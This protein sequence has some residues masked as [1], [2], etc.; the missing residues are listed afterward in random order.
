[1][2]TTAMLWVVVPLLYLPFAVVQ[3][4]NQMPGHCQ[5]EVGRCVD[6]NGDRMPEGQVT[7]LD[8]VD[9]FD[10]DRHQACF[11]MCNARGGIG[12]EL[13]WGAATGEAGC[14]VY[15]GDLLAGDVDVARGDGSANRTCWPFNQCQRLTCPNG[16]APTALPEVEFVCPATERRFCNNY[17]EIMIVMHYRSNVEQCSGFCHQDASCD[18]FHF[19]EHDNNRCM[20]LRAGCDSMGPHT[21]DYYAKADCVNTAP[22]LR[23]PTSRITEITRE[24]TGGVSPYLTN[25]LAYYPKSATRT[26]LWCAEQCRAKPGCAAMSYGLQGGQQAGVC[27]LHEAGCTQANFDG[28]FEYFLREN[29]SATEVLTWSGP[30]PNAYCSSD[31]VRNANVDWN[32]EFTL[33]RCQA[34]CN[35][36]PSCTAVAYG[37][38]AGQWP[39]YCVLC[40]GDPVATSCHADWELYRLT[41]G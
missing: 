15:T 16:G 12:C 25:L 27:L 31:W 5:H 37:A 41:R 3:S 38:A 6:A 2:T 40:Q 20:L 32:T 13:V 1:M 21:H 19:S 17:Y 11:A 7:R 34:K 33:A 35:I 14:Y 22:A 26:A 28:N 39:R 29:F 36:E 4:Q 8:F 10:R 23:S 30:Q 9:L 18:G 24:W